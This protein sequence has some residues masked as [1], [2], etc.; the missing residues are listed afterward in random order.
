MYY[1]QLEHSR[2]IRT[3]QVGKNIE[4]MIHMEVYRYTM[5]EKWR[6]GTN[7]TFVCGYLVLYHGKEEKENK[8][9]QVMAGV[10]IILA[11]VLVY[12]W[13]SAGAI[14]AINFLSHLY[15]FR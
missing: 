4:L 5:Q 6:L 7:S 13:K 9:G 14:S 1:I 10:K 2:V 11:P 15:F 12:L 3:G 8:K